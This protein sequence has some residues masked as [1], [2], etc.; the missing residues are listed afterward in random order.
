[1]NTETTISL[2]KA[3]RRRIHRQM[4]GV[5]EDDPIFVAA[6]AVLR[7]EPVNKSLV[8]SMLGSIRQADEV[9]SPRWTLAV[10][11]LPHVDAATAP[12]SES[13]R[14]LESVIGHDSDVESVIIAD[15]IVSVL[16]HITA[17]AV[18]ALIAYWLHKLCDDSLQQLENGPLFA[19]DTWSSLLSDLKFGFLGVALLS[20]AAGVLAA[21]LGPI[22]E[23]GRRRDLRRQCVEALGAIGSE[24]SVPVLLDIANEPAVKWEA[25]KALAK[26]LVYL[27]D[28]HYPKLSVLLTPKLA[29][30][31]ASADESLRLPLIRALGRMGDGRAVKPLEQF[32][33]RKLNSDELA[34]ASAAL[35]IVRGRQIRERQSE[36][37]LRP[38]DA[39][40]QSLLIPVHASTEELLR[41]AGNVEST[42]E[43]LL[44]PSTNSESS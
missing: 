32:L 43:L 2:T 44:R 7:G 20:L 31:L 27:T 6:D 37:L 38:S 11:V 41:P 39:P 25:R 5:E 17:P 28:G 30:L 36:Q 22:L 4:N 15:T 33:T 24:H 10:S 21:I 23:R 18:A 34:E 12:H 13:A 14:V 16:S 1:M 40:G 35:E 42:P 19:P 3:K 9:Y 29:G 8:W 26:V